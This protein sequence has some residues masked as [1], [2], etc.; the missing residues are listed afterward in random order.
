[1]ISRA[2]KEQLVRLH[3]LLVEGYE[4]APTVA[5]AVQATANWSEMLAAWIHGADVAPDPPAMDIEPVEYVARFYDGPRHGQEIVVRAPR[6][7]SISTF[8]GP[9]GSER[10]VYEFEV[11]TG[12]VV[13]YRH[14][15][16]GADS[17]APARSLT[18]REEEGTR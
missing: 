14:V 15:P 4:K 9:D 2:A 10:N 13:V 7:V 11:D 17:A 8:D 6:P 16:E 18:G 5:H 12:N 1:M 3:E